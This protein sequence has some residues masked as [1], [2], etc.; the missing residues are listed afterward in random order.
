MMASR[1]FV[2]VRNADQMASDELSSLAE[3]LKDPVETSSVVITGDKLDGRSKIVKAAKTAKVLV[4]AKELKGPALRGFVTREAKARGHAIAGPAAAAIVDAIGADLAAIDDALERISLFVGG[5]RPITL[6]DVEASV[7]RVR[8]ESVWVLVDAVSGRDAR[9]ALLAAESLLQDRE[10][11]LR[12]LALLIRQLRMVAR[13]R[14]ALALGLNPP[15]AAKRAGAP[16]FKARELTESAR[17]FAFDDLRRAFGI[18]AEADL[19]L[20]G[21]RRPDGATLQEAILRLCSPH[22][23]SR[24]SAAVRGRRRLLRSGA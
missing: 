2:L 6:E 4:E 8:T 9:R 11:P 1:R 19:E 7:T 18:L 22:G 12:I 16:P 17:R 13:M 10:P 15:E 23:G 5:G 14:E 3:L 20:K 21:A 24:Y